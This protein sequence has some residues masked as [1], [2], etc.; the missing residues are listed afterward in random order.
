MSAPAPGPAPAPATVEVNLNI[1][2]A[3][4]GTIDIF[5]EAFVAPVN[6]IEADVKLPASALYTA[7]NSMFEFWEPSDATGTRK[8]ALA[9]DYT[10]AGEID[11]AD[12]TRDWQLL[13]REL[14]NGIQE[15]LE[16][17]FDATLAT[18]F[19]NVKYAAVHKSLLNF[20]DLA[21]RSYLHYVLGHV[22]ATFAISNDAAFKSAMLARDPVHITTP[23]GV[24]DT[25]SSTA[26]GTKA[27]A[28][29][30]NLLVKAI[31]S[32]DR[33]Q[34]L[35]IADQV[36]GQDASRASGEDNN[37]ITGSKRQALKFIAG[38]IIYMNIQLQTPN[39]VL[40]NAAQQVSKTELEGRFT[41]ENY[42]LKITLE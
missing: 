20:G 42:T 15:C 14:A 29:L 41:G 24:A 21:Y 17:E 38:D 33:T 5:T 25:F 4:S 6:V 9:G 10:A 13:T 16:G 39:I 32:K 3:A 2:V 37:D 30:A 35:A 11:D 18:P 28:N 8:A 36:I 34:I 23:E 7:T 12:N 27:C 1:A 26:A 22:D 40:G 19:N 31:V